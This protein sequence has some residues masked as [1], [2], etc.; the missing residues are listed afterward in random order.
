MKGA[1]LT[2][3]ESRAWKP[4]LVGWSDDVLQWYSEVAE[5]LATYNLLAI[6]VCDEQGHLLGA[7]TVDDVLD[8][9]LPANWRRR[10]T[11]GATS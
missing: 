6:P 2:V 7:I 1:P 5:Q 3:A 9:T 8:R 10:P 4:E 11:A